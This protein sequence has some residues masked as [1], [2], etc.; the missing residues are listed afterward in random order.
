MRIDNARPTRNASAR[1]ATDDDEDSESTIIRHG[2]AAFSF[3]EM[4]RFVRELEARPLA[5][6]LEDL[7]GLLELPDAKYALVSLAVGKRMRKSAEDRAALEPQ[8]RALLRVGPPDV[9]K[10]CEDLLKPFA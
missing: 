8:L 4:G 6:L 10:R 2:K 3:S 1:M 7:P 9:K 5:R